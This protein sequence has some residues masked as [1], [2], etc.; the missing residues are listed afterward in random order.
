MGNSG[1]YTGEKSEVHCSRLIRK[2]PVETV[3][4]RQSKPVILEEWEVGEARKL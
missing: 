2:R 3:F 4:L 1:E